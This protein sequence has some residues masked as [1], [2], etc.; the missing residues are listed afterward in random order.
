MVTSVGP[1]PK[2]ITAKTWNAKAWEG[3]VYLREG[4]RTAI[5]GYLMNPTGSLDK[6]TEVWRKVGHDQSKL[7]FR[8]IAYIETQYQHF[9]KL[10]FDSMTGATTQPAE[11]VYPNISAKGKVPPYSTAAAFGV[12]Q[13]RDPVPTYSQIWH[14][15][16]NIDAGI[17]VAA[18]KLKVAE[19]R[20][21]NGGGSEDP[22]TWLKLETYALYEGKRYWAVDADMDQW[23]PDNREDAYG[24][25]GKQ[26]EIS[27]P[28][29]F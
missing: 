16:R 15:R 4:L 8:I 29:D 25:K 1:K 28:A 12:M 26:Y 2:S 22:A 13:V 7:F 23:V 11:V 27:P 9:R 24:N 3:N 6:A 17:S 18:Q 19:A 21:R 10:M 20:L 14:W 5:T